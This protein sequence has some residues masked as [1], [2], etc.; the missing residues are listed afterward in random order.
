[1]RAGGTGLPSFIAPVHPVMQ[2]Y[3]IGLERG[4]VLEFTGELVSTVSREIAHDDYTKTVREY[5]LYRTDKGRYLLLLESRREVRSKMHYL[6]FESP[7]DV[8]KYIKR[9]EDDEE[10]AE[11]LFRDRT[12]GR[13]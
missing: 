5:A 10:V 4:E 11:G 3:R 12:S 1:M 9:F 2:K 7:D 6:K 8:Y 13:E